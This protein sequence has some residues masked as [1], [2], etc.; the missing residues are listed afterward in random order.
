[1]EFEV[2]IALNATYASDGS[3]VFTNQTIAFLLESEDV[4]YTP[5][6][7]VPPIVGGLAYT[8]PRPPRR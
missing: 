1:M 7:W 3:P 8:L 6:E 4:G 2:S 5:H